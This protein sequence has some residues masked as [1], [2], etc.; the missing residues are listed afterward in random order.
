MSDPAN[1][2]EQNTAE[3]VAQISHYIY[4]RDI[5]AAKGMSFYDL[6]DI[7]VEDLKAQAR[8]DTV[9][10]ELEARKITADMEYKS[11]QA[12]GFRV[13][14]KWMASAYKVAI[15]LLKEGVERK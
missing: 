8:I 15:A 6:V 14:R 3:G 9:V 11:A 13:E 12:Y 7:V 10:K 1:N 4:I 2:V 5:A